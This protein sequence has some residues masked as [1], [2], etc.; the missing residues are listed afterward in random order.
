MKRVSF[1]LLLVLSIC[2]PDVQALVDPV[3]ADISEQGWMANVLIKGS[4]STN[5]SLLCKGSLIDPYWVLTSTECLTDALDIIE[6]FVASD[7]A[8]F[9][10]ALGNLGGLFKVEERISSPDG[11]AL[12]LRL[13]RPADN[14]PIRMLYRS[15]AQLRGVQVRLFNNESSASLG[16]GF[17]NPL[18][19]TPVSCLLGGAK[20]FSDG[21]M[22]YVTSRLNYSIFPLMARGRVID[23]LAADAPT[24]PL[25]ATVTPDTSGGRLYVDFGENDSYPCHEDLGAPI[26]A[27]LGG[28]LVQVGLLVGAGMTTGVPLCNGSFLNHMISMEGLKEFIEGSIAKGKFAQ[29][30]PARAE[31]R[32]EQLDGTRVRFFWDAIDQAEGYRMLA[33]AALGYEPIQVFDLAG[34]REIT[35]ELD[36]GTTYSLSLQ[37]YNAECTGAMSRPLSIG[38]DS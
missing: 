16:D 14:E 31:L 29:R 33:T 26:I 30:C 5:F 22:C 28:E 21:R 1:G 34:V 38:F 20:F 3:P 12:L 4:R 6:D 36:I 10:V 15:P 37:G 18:G 8:E 24:S 35:V 19:A 2:R 17:Y 27:T 13:A 7:A 32:F 11:N 23:P 9:A 25:N